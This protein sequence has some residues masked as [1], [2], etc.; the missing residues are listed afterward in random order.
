MLSSILNG[1]QHNHSGI[2]PNDFT[3]YFIR[4]DAP[5]GITE[6]QQFPQSIQCTN[7]VPS[8]VT[9]CLHYVRSWYS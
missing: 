5:P 8:T 7:L 2:S 6:S 4:L 9:M 3:S 1:L